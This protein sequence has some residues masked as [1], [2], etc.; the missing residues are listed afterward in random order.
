M[1]LITG[2]QQYP[3]FFTGVDTRWR[4]CGVGVSAL[5]C[6]LRAMVGGDGN[7]GHGVSGVSQADVHG[8]AFSGYF[9]F[10]E[11]RQASDGCVQ[12]GY[13]VDYGYTG[14]YGRHSFVSRH[15]GDAGHS[16]AYRV[17]ADLIPVGAKLT[18]RGHIYHN[19][20]GVNLF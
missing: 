18:I 17:I 13:P 10:V 2:R 8:L 20:T 11:C 19:D 15:H 9:T 12:R 7:L 1:V 16:L 14:S 4:S 6:N 5:G 3:T